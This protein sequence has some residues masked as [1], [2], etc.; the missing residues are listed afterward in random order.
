MPLSAH[1]LH[2]NLID[3]LVEVIRVSWGVFEG[4]RD[5]AQAYSRQPMRDDHNRV[6]KS[7]SDVIEGK[8]GRVC[9]FLA[10]DI[11]SKGKKVET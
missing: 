7:L 3:K 11:A 1:S 5:S 9:E 2:N 8:E 10:S 4:A 6:Y